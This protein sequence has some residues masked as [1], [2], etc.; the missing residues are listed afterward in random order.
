MP[1]QGRGQGRGQ[2]RGQ[3]RGQGMQAGQGSGRGG[4]QVGGRSGQGGGLG[5]G[6]FCICPKCGKKVQHRPGTPCLDER[7]PSCGVAL[8]REGSPHHQEIESRRA[9]REPAR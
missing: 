4:S 3:G 2:E 1:K 6:G 8:V 5:G 7:C 9:E